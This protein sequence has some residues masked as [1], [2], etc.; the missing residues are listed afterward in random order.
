MNI[1]VTIFLA[2]FVSVAMVNVSAS[3]DEK[4]N[5]K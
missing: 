1:L 4:N 3:E 5:D 2:I